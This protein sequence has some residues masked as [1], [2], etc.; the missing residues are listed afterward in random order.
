[1]HVTIH[2]LTSITPWDASEPS[3]GQ[4][5][6]LLRL[7]S[8]L[9]ASRSNK[10]Y[11]RYLCWTGSLCPRPASAANGVRSQKSVP[12]QELVL[13]TESAN[14]CQQHD[15]LTCHYFRSLHLLAALGNVART[16]IHINCIVAVMKCVIESVN[17]VLKANCYLR[18]KSSQQKYCC[19]LSNNL[20]YL[21]H[22]VLPMDLDILGTLSLFKLT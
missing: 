4:F 1:M 22:L 8:D 9:N 12:L 17:C 14:V 3:V 15:I 19:V 18:C 6:D 21:V 20:Q 13:W 10:I 11:T 5:P 16:F 2:P 7:S